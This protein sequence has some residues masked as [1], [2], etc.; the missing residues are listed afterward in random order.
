MTEAPDRQPVAQPRKGRRRT[1]VVVIIVAALIASGVV[2]RHYTNPERVRDLAKGY[3]QHYIRGP[4][5]IGS[6]DFSWWDG[7]RLFDVAVHEVQRAASQRTPPAGTAPLNPVLSCREI[8]LSHDRS[9]VLSGGLR[10]KGI[11]ALEPACLIVRDA[12]DGYTNLEGLLRFPDVMAQG[13]S[14]PLPTIELRDAQVRVLSREGAL[15]RVVQ[16]LRLHIRARP[17]QRDA[18]VYDVVWQGGDGHTASGYSR[19]D[20]HTGRLRNV[21]GGLP[22]MSIEAVML[23]VN[24]GYDGAGVWCNLLGLDG[25]VRAKDYDLST[26][27]RT[28][29]SRSATIELSDAS[30][31]IP[32]DKREQPFPPD[33]RYLRF[34]EV[35]GQVQLT[36]EGIRADFAG[37]FHGSEC[38]VSAVLHGAVEKLATLNDVDFD[39]RLSVTG[40]D[41]PRHD[42]DGP[43]AEV[44][45]INRWHQLAGFYRDYD[46]HGPADLEVEVTKRAGAD[47]PIVVRRVLLTAQGG[48]AS[49]RYLPYRGY[50]IAG[51]I[52]YTPDGV[53]IRD[54]RGSHGDG[55]VT[56][57]GRLSKPTEQAA[58]ELSIKATGIPIDETLVEALPEQYRRIREQFNLKGSID[59]EI[60]LTLP[61]G[62]DQ[63]PAKW[64]M[65]PTITLRDVS[66]RFD[67][68]PYPVDHLTGM[69]LADEDRLRLLNVVG[70]S[71][72][73]RVGLEGS[74]ELSGGHLTG[75]DLA[76]D[77]QDIP[78]DDLLLAALPAEARK[79]VAAFHPRGSFDAQTSLTLDA[80]TKTV[81]HTSDIVLKDVAIRHETLPVEV[82]GITGRLHIAP[83]DVVLDGLTGR[84]NDAIL[85]AEGSIS[86]DGGR[87]A[88]AV[89]IRSR[90]LQL[91]EALCAALPPKARKAVVHWKIDGPVATET[92]VSTTP[93]RADEG[94][95]VR[96][97]ARLQGATVRH[98]LF[99]L[100]FDDVRTEITIDGVGARAS[101][102]EARY[103]TASVRADFDMRHIPGAEQGT[104]KLSATGVT[105]DDSLRGLLPEEM[106][107]A[108]NRLE[109]A[110]SVDVYLNSLR[111]RRSSVEGPLEWLVEGYVEF[112]NAGI[113]GLAG[114]ERMSGTLVGS[115]SLIDRLGGTSLTGNLTLS[116]VNV[117]GQRLS[118]TEGDWSYARVASGEGMLVLDPIQGRV[119]DGSLTGALEV[120]FDTSRAEYD[121]STTIHKMQIEPF[122]NADRAS[123]APD[124]E[125]LDVRG[126]ADGHLYISGV[127]GDRASRQGGGRF[128]IIDGHIYRL[129]II[130]RILNVLSL[131]IPDEDA[132][133]EARADFFIVGK[134]VQIADI[135]LRGSV[136]ALVGS[137]SVTLPDRGVDLNL[138][139]VGPRLWTHVPV[140]ADV[141]EVA[142][143]ELVE[144]HVT[145]PLS[146]PT[147]RP[148][149]FRRISEEFKRLF[150]KRKPK[151]IQP[152]AP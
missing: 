74:V 149:P 124:S 37:Q 67:G 89:M 103:G 101:N 146:Q 144:L 26:A 12:A 56:V 63:Q 58:K 147:V 142:S 104:I 35:N 151:R 82:A 51:K 61:A 55:T 106:N 47:E 97:V 86:R 45:F 76:I 62:S 6:A 25:T 27:L 22:W 87:Q 111:C 120:A 92:I 10:V 138:V 90:N 152:A 39:V 21:S 78:F 145:G 93:A 46:P 137:G 141:V 130:L 64:R 30:I 98:R 125:R 33:Q 59:A 32:I 23:A 2:Y 85:S 53:F 5:T 129:P 126:R 134:R 132:F 122:I 108:W 11:I 68:F 42:P 131:S 65:R 9:S 112:N 94:P 60:E 19:V 115:G 18:D 81:V 105:L 20:L 100:V 139:N 41:L 15:D 44:R 136:L 84:Y 50:D 83:N 17:S 48:D 57:N 117:L 118:R 14:G 91:D 99:P 29:G 69:L 40:L 80:D 8:R 34:E 133:D 102:V 24:A 148:R 77:A 79:Q 66:A 70:R 113:P 75:L 31:S 3:L 96:T 72:E 16:D 73:A 150:R 119:Y 4:V 127:I 116:T 1:L 13:V 110:G 123:R 107:A 49:C 109:P 114:I 71:G 143:G 135:A 38:R 54:I 95:S 128:E 121:L 88:T 140:L 43:P 36:P 7:V 52:E 28:E